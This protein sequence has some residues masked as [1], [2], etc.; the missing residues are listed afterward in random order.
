M[1]YIKST[2]VGIVTFILATIGY[3]ICATTL[4][5]RRHPQPAGVE[6]GFDLRT[7]V[8]SWL[9]WLVAIA[10]FA[11]GFYWEFRRATT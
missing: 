3:V 11:L 6:V 4:F 1:G 5:M 10:A 7:L 2:L 8:G 9:F